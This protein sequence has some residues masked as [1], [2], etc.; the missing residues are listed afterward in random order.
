VGSRNPIT[1]IAGCLPAPQAAMPPR[2]QDLQ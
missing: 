1:G 2:R